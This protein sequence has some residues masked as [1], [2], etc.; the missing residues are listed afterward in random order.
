MGKMTSD[1]KGQKGNIL[2]WSLLIMACGSIVLG[3]LLGYLNTSLRLAQKSEENAHSYYAADSGIEDAYI[4]LMNDKDS[5]HWTQENITK[6]VRDSYSMN[7][8]SVNVRVEDRGENVY[9]IQST[10]SDETGNVSHIKVY[11]HNVWP[12]FLNNALVSNGDIIIG[13]DV[14]VIGGGIYVG[15]LSIGG[16][17]EGELIQVD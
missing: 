10:A 12:P 9:E 14:N 2:L 13:S 8:Y 16:T 5:T 1:R 11:I 4:F 6:W 15:S 3:G 7:G 17:V